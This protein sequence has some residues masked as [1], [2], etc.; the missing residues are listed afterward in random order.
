[1]TPTRNR[2][3]DVLTRPLVLGA[4]VLLALNDWVFKDLFPGPLTGKLSDV[5]GLF[6]FPL[7]V[8][9][10]W[11][12]IQARLRA[13]RERSESLTPLLVSG[14][15]I[16]VFFTLLKSSAATR[17]LYLAP[18]ELVGVQAAVAPDLSDLL[19]LPVIGCA[20]LYGRSFL[21][22]SGAASEQG[23]Q[24]AARAGVIAGF[25]ALSVGTPAPSPQKTTPGKTTA[26][27]ATP[28]PTATPSQTPTATATPTPG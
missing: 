7:V 28:T 14:L 6:A 8:W 9:G 4:I 16:A 18:Y 11:D 21:N 20:W 1:M 17:S 2:P 27:T 15:G 19:C 22:G 24:S 26:P 12:W 13:G 23:L 5:A 10:G 3:Q 25:V